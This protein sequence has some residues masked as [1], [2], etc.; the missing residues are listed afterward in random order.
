MMGEV[1]G[2]KVDIHVEH[3]GPNACKKI[4]EMK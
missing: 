1:L 2:K 4:M 3:A